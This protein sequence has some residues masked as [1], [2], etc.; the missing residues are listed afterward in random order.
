M[1][2]SVSRSMLDFLAWV[3]SRPRTYHEAME[4]WQTTCPRHTTWEDAII[5][6]LIEV[7]GGGDQSAVTLTPRGREVLESHTGETRPLPAQS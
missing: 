7:W 3:S 5:G 1:A 2:E 4:A 6:G